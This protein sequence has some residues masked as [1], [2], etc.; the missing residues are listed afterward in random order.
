MVRSFADNDGSS[1]PPTIDASTFNSGSPI[2]AGSAAPGGSVEV[3]V[4]GA[5]Y[6][7]VVDESGRW[8]VDTATATPISG[9][10]VPLTE[11]SN[12]IAVTSI[13]SDGNRS[14]DPTIGD[15][16]VDTSIVTPQYLRSPLMKTD[17]GR[18]TFPMQLRSM[19]FLL[20]S[21]MVIIR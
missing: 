1:T 17:F 21:R 8:S 5:T 10:F 14:T 7:V 20:R 3:L 2:L 6:S 11:G 4:G 13:D 9:S 16:E 18:W 15:V 19:G 12:E